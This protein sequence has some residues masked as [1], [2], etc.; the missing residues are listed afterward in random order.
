MTSSS[1][2]RSH[3]NRPLADNVADPH[4][5][6]VINADDPTFTSAYAQD[7]TVF[8]IVEGPWVANS[9]PS[10]WIG[11]R[12]DPGAAT[13]GGLYVYRT[14]LDRTGFDPAAVVFSGNWASDNSV[15]LLINGVFSG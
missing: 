1:W 15:E 13:A 12:A 6:L 2:A 7:P 8:P 3:P 11:P 9:E 10:W 5:T 14:T 4:Y